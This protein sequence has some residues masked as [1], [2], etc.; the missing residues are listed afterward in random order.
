M[1]PDFFEGPDPKEATE[2]FFAFPW[3]AAVL[4]FSKWNSVLAFGN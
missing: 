3:G 2:A 1:A 4:Q